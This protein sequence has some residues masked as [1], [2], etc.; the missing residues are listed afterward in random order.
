VPPDVKRGLPRRQ[1]LDFRGSAPGSGLALG[2]YWAR[3][4]TQG[5]SPKI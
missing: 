3:G 2:I 4:R 5:H 1:Q